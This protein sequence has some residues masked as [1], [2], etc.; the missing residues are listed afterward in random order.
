MPGYRVRSAEGGTL[1]NPLRTLSHEAKLVVS[2]HPRVAIP[3]ARR[4]GHGVVVDRTSVILIEGYPRSANSF[5]VA[6]FDYAQGGHPRI[7]H[8][9]HA[10]A[11]VMEAVRL[12]VPAIV[13]VRDPD[14]AVL[15]LVIARPHV[16]IPQAL[17][18]YAGFYEPLLRHRDG[19]AVGPFPEVTTDFGAVIL[20]V[21]QRFGTA[22][23]E[24]L[25]TAE[26]QQ[27]VFDAMDA[28]WRSRVG[29]SEELERRVGR[30]SEERE[31]LKAE[32]RPRYES[33]E[34]AGKRERARTLYRVFT[35]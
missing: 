16:T 12:G 19:F 5:A 6:A 18:M 8:H 14:D 23:Q 28:Y 9:L 20:R 29:E 34:L 30:P 13:L 15:E 31:R 7:A 25:H 3:L 22:F 1:E 24:F 26:N 33:D 21:N 32:L 35:S 11:H 2:R 10:S 27:V 4:R 17:R